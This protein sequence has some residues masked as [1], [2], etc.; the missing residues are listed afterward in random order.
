MI[1]IEIALKSLHI[2]VTTFDLFFE[3]HLERKKCTLFLF[4]FQLEDS[5]DEN[6]EEVPTA[7]QSNGES[8]VEP[9]PTLKITVKNDIT[10]SN[11]DDPIPI[12]G[13]LSISRKKTSLL[14]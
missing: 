13:S 8:A 11:D 9:I 6:N 10:N 2:F 4:S 12:E 7:K 1:T 14:S 3:S 5:A